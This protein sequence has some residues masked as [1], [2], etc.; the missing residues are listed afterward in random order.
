MP[1]PIAQATVDD[2]RTVRIIAAGDIILHLPIINSARQA[3]G[4]FDFRPIFAHIA[5]IL[6]KGDIAVAVLETVLAGVENKGFTGYPLFNSPDEIVDALLWSGI[7]LVFTAHN[8][9]LDRGESGVLRTQKI[10]RQYGMAYVGTNTGPE[11]D[12]RVNLQIVNGFRMAFLSYTTFTNGLPSPK[13][14]DWVVNR[15]QHDKVLQDID[16]A[17][18][19]G[20]D[21]IIC[22]LHAGAEYQVK[23]DAVQKE[24][25]NFLMEHGV[26]LVLGSHPHIIQPMEWRNR[27]SNEGLDIG[28]VAFSLGNF[29]SNQQWRYSDCGLVLDIIMTKLPGENRPTITSLNAI[30]IWVHRYKNHGKTEYRIL[31]V[32]LGG[33]ILDDPLLSKEDRLRLVQ[34]WED[35]NRVIGEKMTWHKESVIDEL[36]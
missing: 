25:A 22:A 13:G 19:K 10:L 23:P 28:L 30:P 35:T 11:Y 2:S 6:Q 14:K 7:D 9:S 12:S 33:E 31:P 16:L 18:Q 5:P 29:L 32:P 27:M 17:R 36:H 1:E 34:V 4:G 3:N 24:A 8:H 20:A 21:V 26:D 15:F